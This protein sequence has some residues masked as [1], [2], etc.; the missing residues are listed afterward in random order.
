MHA[1][2]DL[3]A[4]ELSCPASAISISTRAY[5]SDD[6]ATADCHPR[7]RA[8]H[9]SLVLPADTPL[10]LHYAVEVH[11]LADISQFHGSDTATDGSCPGLFTTSDIDSSSSCSD[12]GDD[13]DDATAAARLPGSA[14]ADDFD[15]F[16]PHHGSLGLAPL[17]PLPRDIQFTTD[18]PSTPRPEPHDTAVAH[19]F[20][21]STTLAPAGIAD[22]LDATG[23]LVDSPAAIDPTAA[24]SPAAE[25]PVDT[26]STDLPPPA[27]VGAPQQGDVS[28]AP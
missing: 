14:W 26:T 2:F 28:S 5:T 17:R 20:M 15:T 27:T 21:L 11:L 12:D 18:T 23:A 22:D 25:G 16:E 6:F 13:D 4:R 24:T 19:V 3:I 9:T 10:S 8:G 1:V 7:T